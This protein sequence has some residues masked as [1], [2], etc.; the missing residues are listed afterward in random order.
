M[1]YGAWRTSR[2]AQEPV[3][4]QVQGEREASKDG[5]EI[6]FVHARVLS[7]DART[8]GNA[9]IESREGVAR[10]SMSKGRLQHEVRAGR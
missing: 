2:L 9:S 1:G 5:F 7:V 4:E 3:A 8:L 6:A 10:I